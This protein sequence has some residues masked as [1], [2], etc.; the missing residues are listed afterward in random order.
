MQVLDLLRI[1]ERWTHA[2]RAPM[3]PNSTPD[4]ILDTDAS[5]WGLGAWLRQRRRHFTNP[6]A[7]YNTT[8][9][10]RMEWPA[11][12]RCESIN[13]REAAAVRIAFDQFRL[14]GI[15]LSSRACRSTA[16]IESC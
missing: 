12:F 14:G 8:A 6:H 5:D 10:L 16:T 9:A 4:F 1:P 15:V 7:A 11:C 2:I 3:R 13:V